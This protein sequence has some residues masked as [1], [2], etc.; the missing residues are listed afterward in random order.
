V[1]L[2]QG[3]I[4]NPRRKTTLGV[5]NLGLGRLLLLDFWKVRL[6]QGEEEMKSVA[7]ARLFLPS[8]MAENFSFRGHETRTYLCACHLGF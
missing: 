5:D 8:S 4:T 1:L 3:S 7:M 6:A 2:Q